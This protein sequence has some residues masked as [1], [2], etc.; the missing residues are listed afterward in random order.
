M[1]GEHDHH[2][3]S[4]CVNAWMERLTTGLPPDRWIHAFDRAFAVLWRRASQTLGEVTLRAILDRVLYNA[5]EHF[6]I[7]SHLEVGATGLSCAELQEHASSVSAESLADGIRYV[8]V[9]F[10]TLLGNL[11]AQILTPALH[12]E[13]SSLSR[14]ETASTENT[15]RVESHP[16]ESTDRKD[17]ED[18][19]S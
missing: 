2:D 19:K 4:A 9:E 6:A 18:G 16:R 12:A 14:D 7:L 11:T 3:H 8:M 17:G 1:D 10:L 5:T 15:A 13:L